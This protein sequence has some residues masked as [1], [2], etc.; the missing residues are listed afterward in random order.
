MP[1]EDEA[2]RDETLLFVVDSPVDED[3]DSELMPDE[4][5]VE[6]EETLLFVVDRPE[7]AEVESEPT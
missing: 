1:L 5:E 7:D 4:A 6:S 2:E 3:V